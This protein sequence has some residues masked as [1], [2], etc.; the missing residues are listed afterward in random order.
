M[1]NSF[2]RYTGSRFGEPKKNPETAKCAIAPSCGAYLR[3]FEGREQRAREM[4][5]YFYRLAAGNHFRGKKRVYQQSPA[6]IC[7][8]CCPLC[9]CYDTPPPAVAPIC[10]SLLRRHN[11]F[12]LRRNMGA[13]PQSDL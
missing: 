4:K 5:E 2:R 11:I 6:I 12:S 3:E 9:L 1:T 7:H 10:H 13:Q 8:G